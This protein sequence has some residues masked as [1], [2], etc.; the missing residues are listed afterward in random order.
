MRKHGFHLLFDDSDFI[1]HTQSDV[2]S[3][4]WDEIANEVACRR[5]GWREAEQLR[6]MTT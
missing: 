4:G 6:L 2:G 1:E 5:G 3:L